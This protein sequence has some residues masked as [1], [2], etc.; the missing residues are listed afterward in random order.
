MEKAKLFAEH[1]RATCDALTVLDPT[2]EWMVCFKPLLEEDI[3]APSGIS[4]DDTN[5]NGLQ[6]ARRGQGEGHRRLSWIWLNSADEDS[7][8]GL[9]AGKHIVRVYLTKLT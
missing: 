2:S 4:L 5:T 3:Q 7:A 9:E 8:E 1:Y 6:R